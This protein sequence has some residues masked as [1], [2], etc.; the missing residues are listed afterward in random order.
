MKRAGL[1][2]LAAAAVLAGIAVAAPAQ[3]RDEARAALIARAKSFELDTPYV[4][5]PGE[6]ID[7]H[8]AG[9]AKVMCSAVFI[10]GLESDFA[11]E[12]VGYFTAP[13]EQRA[14]LGKP[15]ID[16]V[17]KTVDVP[18]PNRTTRTSV[19]LGDQG[20]VTLPIGQTSV[21]FKPVRVQSKLLDPATQPWP[22]GDAP[23][24]EPLPPDAISAISLRA[25][26]SAKPSNLSIWNT[27]DPGPP[28]TRVR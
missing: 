17:K 13:Y 7:H 16:R 9:F 27:K 3:S 5:P 2:F 20:C 14:K 1:R 22:M 23:P 6:A 19:Y 24:R 11:A 28:A 10:T 15:V 21:S 25:I 18:V 8:A 4:P 12:N 26:A